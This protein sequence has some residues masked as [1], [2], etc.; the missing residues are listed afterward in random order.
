[1]S[2]V[3]KGL[4]L[5]ALALLIIVASTI[6]A[7][8]PPSITSVSSPIVIGNSFTI[9]GSGFTNGSV[10]NFFVSTATGAVKF[11]PLNPAKPISSASLTVP[12]PV[13]VS[14]QGS[15]FLGQGVAAVQVVNTDQGFAA[16]NAV[17]A[18]FFGNN[19]DGFPNLTGI[20]GIG[21]AATSANPDY[22]T[23]NVETHLS[24][25]TTI[26]L[27]GNG[28]DLVHGVAV[29]L[30]CD[31]PGGKITTIFLGA[32]NPGL[33]A[34]K[35]TVSLP[36]T[37]AGGPATGPGSLV[38]SNRG[39]AG[40][41]A[42]KSNAVSVPIGAP[43]AITNIQQ[44]GCTVTVE[45]SGFAVNGAGLS[46]LTVINLFNQ[47]GGVAVNLGGLK[48][49]GAPKLPLSVVSS[50]QFS[51]SLAGTGFVPGPSYVQVLN[52]PFFPFASSG[53]GPSGAFTAVKCVASTPTPT[54]TPTSAMPT[55]LPSATPPAPSATPTPAGVNALLPQACSLQT[56]IGIDPINNIAYVPVRTLDKGHNS[57]L[58]VVDLTV[59]AA[60]P[61][62]KTI[63]LAGSLQTIS[64]AY[65][66]FNH[67][68]LADTR[69]PNN[70]VTVFEISTVTESVI[71]VVSLKGMVQQTASV[72]TSG[73]LAH[74]GRQDTVEA[75]NR[76][77]ALAQALGIRKWAK[78][79]ASEFS[80]LLR[81]QPETG[82]WGSVALQPQSGGIVEDLRNNRA[83]V[84]GTKMLGLLDTSKSPPVWN[85]S[86]IIGLSIYPESFALNSNTGF[87]FI[88]NLG[89]DS[90]I[91]TAQTSLTE[92]PFQS[93][94]NEA[95][96][97]GIAWD[98]TTNIVMHGE[99]DGA[100]QSY[101]FNMGT[102][103]I[104]Q[105]P[106]I[107][108]PIPAPG[109]GFESIYGFGYGPGGQA[110]INCATHQAV[111]AN[112]FGP[113]LS[114]IQMPSQPVAGQLDNNGQP[115]SGTTPDNASVYTIA[116]T[117][118]PQV[119][120]GGTKTPL[121]IISS[122]N[123]L[124]VDPLHNFAYMLGDDWLSYHTWT[125][126]SGIP[127]FLVRVDLSKPVFGASPT[128]GINGKTFWTPSAA[129]IPLP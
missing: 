22:A 85:P 63:S 10:V 118:I 59:G 31:C 56:L 69:D 121:G 128:G 117:A 75:D 16:S 6:A 122:P 23:D 94:P 89:A 35:L 32:G 12:V 49:G 4:A 54:P 27:N 44:T 55:P 13:T 111:I 46:N 33:T 115:G 106:A 20:D 2:V 76:R 45:G 96:T 95:V 120:V 90:L 72:I 101:A 62:L 124:T 67:T 8:A 57:Q 81:S 99:L 11:G 41:Y 9:S 5:P 21:L 52:P 113:N 119:E 83:I 19:A 1:M 78:M 60:S 93:T 53:D 105:A 37:G 74:I 104:M 92:I 66:P 98:I 102:L 77:L 110:V 58:A 107:A 7:A 40:N 86:S 48:S 116:T 43:V 100:D 71:G 3:I 126:N 28:F 88:S 73:A 18:Q 91:D 127:L 47:Q 68:M 114:L 36:A 61:V 70:N 109:L 38:V 84:A 103:D 17:T 15:L 112:D 79:R 80:N 82:P 14:P 51:F 129:A 65:N 64:L 26:T 50:S 34:T 123:S 125:P 42:I 97:D 87:L 39:A 25:G 30:F 108:D 24:P 29:D